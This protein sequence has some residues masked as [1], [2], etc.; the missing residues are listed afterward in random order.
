MSDFLDWNELAETVDGILGGFQEVTITRNAVGIYDPAT[1]TAPVTTT[2]ETGK[3]ALL[4]YQWRNDGQSEVNGTSILQGDKD[5]WLSAVGISVPQIN[6]TVV[7]SGKTY[8][9]K[10]VKS[11]NPAGTDV[12]HRCNVRGV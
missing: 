4:E 8:T 1:G 10:Q 2:V 3:G 9:I 6:D 11:E 12:Y 5:L 7:A